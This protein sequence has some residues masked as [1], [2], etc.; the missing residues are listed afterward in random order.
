VSKGERR[1]RSPFL[2]V[3]WITAKEALW[4]DDRDVLRSIPK[5]ISTKF[6]KSVEVYEKLACSSPLFRDPSNRFRR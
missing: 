2:F 3:T 6:Y 5:A 1:K 4:E